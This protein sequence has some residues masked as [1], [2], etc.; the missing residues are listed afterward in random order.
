MVEFNYEEDLAIDPSQLD[1]EWLQHSGICEVY[2]DALNDAQ[3]ELNKL[4][5]LT[6]TG[7]SVHLNFF[8]SEEEADGLGILDGEAFIGDSNCPYPK[9]YDPKDGHGYSGVD[10]DKIDF[11][12]LSA[13]NVMAALYEKCKEKEERFGEKVTPKAMK[14]YR[15]M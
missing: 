10:L 15:G 11:E 12:N 4:E 14:R 3:E 13:R 6:R 2:I 7:W 5:E 1:E 8:Y 9:E